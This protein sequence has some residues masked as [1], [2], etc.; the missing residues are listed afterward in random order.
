MKP[1]KKKSAVKSQKKGLPVKGDQGV[2]LVGCLKC[3]T[4]INRTKDEY[5]IMILMRGRELIVKEY[6]CG[7]H[8][9]SKLDLL[10]DQE[11]EPK[12]I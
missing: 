9:I 6:L 8:K 12:N 10:L 11:E 1:Q 5:Q 2:R 3:A 4:P 7:S